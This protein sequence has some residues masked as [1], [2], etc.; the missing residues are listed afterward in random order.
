MTPNVSPVISFRLRSPAMWVSAMRADGPV[1]YVLFQ[2]ARGCFSTIFL[3]TSTDSF[4][5]PSPM[6]PAR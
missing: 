1:T 5:S 4:A 2:A 3:V 6:F